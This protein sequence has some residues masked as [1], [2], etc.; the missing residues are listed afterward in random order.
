M[1]KLYLLSIIILVFIGA[2]KQNDGAM[3]EKDNPLLAKFDTPFG[4]PPFNKILNK[5]YLPAFKEAMKQQKEEIDVIAENKE[6][7]TFENTIVA[8]DNSGELLNRVSSVFYNLKSADTN[9]SI[10]QISKEVSPLLSK[11][12]DDIALND[13]LFKRI[14]SVYGKKENFNLNT[15]QNMLLK[16][17]YENFVRGGANL[18]E[19]KKARFREINEKLSMLTLQFG[20]NLL[21]E[22]NGFRIVID[23]DADLAGLPE[24]VIQAAK[25]TAE[26]KGYKGKWVFTI[27]KPSL[28]P[29]LTYSE[30]RELREKLFK[31]YISR[32][33]NGGKND[34]KE[35]IKQ[36]VNL[37]VERAHLLGFNN[38][39]EYVLDVNMAKNPENV[40]DLLNKIWGAALPVAK[41]EA[42]SLQAMIYKD[43]NNFKLEPW[44]WWYYSEKIRKEKYNLDEEELRPYF[45]LEN[46]REGMFLLAN[47]LYGI[48]FTP[49]NDIPLY[50]KDGEAFEVK[51]A[52]G[53]HIGIF[54]TDFFPRESK[55]GGAWMTSFRKQSRIKGKN[56]TPVIMTVM[57][58]T[59]PTAGKPSLLS[60]EEVETMFHEFGHALHG[61]LSNCTY[62]TLSGTSVARDFVELPSQVME[63]WASEPEMLRLYARHY[64]TG[65]VIPEELI[66]KL[67]NSSLFNQGFRTIEYLA[68]SYLD[69]KWHTMTKKNN[70]LDVNDF[71]ESVMKEIG[72][73]PEII[74]RYRSTN[75]A[76]IFSGGYSSGYYGY[77]WAAVL[78]ADAF[79]AFKETGLFDQKTAK[80]FR[81]KL[82]SKGGT[83]EP[84]NLYKAFR[85]KE[86]SIEPH[87][88]RKGLL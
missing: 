82:I 19:N 8:F 2:C 31:A 15:E 11:H 86:P 80:A 72:M 64:E 9:D 41:K 7:A 61:L 45:K 23:N 18:A 20:E 63:N 60:F 54:Y 84:M 25:E 49:V 29:F 6:D 50:H 66:E 1:N 77:E 57:N 62:E 53:T 26:E 43:G 76:H 5:H 69:M 24:S 51:E 85:G 46:V 21:N 70:T 73:L 47:K 33:N 3:T 32:G 68:A 34:N 67:Q 12:K 37:R 75:F 44:D 28:F 71:E 79:E 40:Y 42:E 36:I 88:K 10:N 56:V 13:K 16:K 30:K 59:K 14:K 81:E 17:I 55:R 87:L 83:D 58:F 22:N 35:I 65:E 74:V 38:H 78:D 39:A 52:D 27:L 4:V 48:T